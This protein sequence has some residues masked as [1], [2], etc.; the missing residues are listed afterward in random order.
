L[1]AEINKRKE[2]ILVRLQL[3][4]FA[5]HHPGLEHKA[6]VEPGGT[7]VLVYLNRVKT[8]AANGTLSSVSRISALLNQP[9]ATSSKV[10]SLRI[11]ELEGYA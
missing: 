9:V 5:E 7:F 1:F 2:S 11:D 8:S 6:G 4:K 10:S 3:S